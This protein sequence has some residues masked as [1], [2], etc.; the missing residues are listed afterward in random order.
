MKFNSDMM[1]LGMDG[2]M[3]LENTKWWKK[4]GS[5]HFTVRELLLS[6]EG[7]SVRTTDGRML[8]G[9]ILE[10]YIQSDTPI[11]GQERSIPRID[12]KQ[13]EGI[14]KTAIVMDDID[15][16]PTGNKFG[17]LKYSH[18]DAQFKQPK[19]NRMISNTPNN[20]DPINDPLPRDQ[21]SNTD[22]LDAVSY[23]M[24]DRVMNDIDINDL[25]VININ[26]TEKI[27]NGIVTLH[28]ILNIT[29][30]EIKCYMVNKLLDN[31]HDKIESA[32]DAYF[33]KILGKPELHPDNQEEKL[34]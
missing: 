16:Q 5:D 21:P 8:P 20:F 22:I 4:D 32:F 33:D 14:D 27:N 24:I 13:L 17:S 23:G 15:D 1:D 6:P 11:T 7:F 34:N 26:P 18:P 2:N 19:K 31:L 28:N 30:D 25:M 9:D 3:E 29:R 10:Q 12:P